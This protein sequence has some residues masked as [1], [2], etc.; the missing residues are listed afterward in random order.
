MYIAGKMQERLELSEYFDIR[1]VLYKIVVTKLVLFFLWFS[2]ALAQHFATQHLHLSFK[3]AINI[4]GY[5][6][7]EIINLLFFA[8]VSSQEIYLNLKKKMNFEIYLPNVE[9]GK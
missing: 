4:L 8:G 1:N 2:L 5:S 7:L 9:T 3:M 6:I